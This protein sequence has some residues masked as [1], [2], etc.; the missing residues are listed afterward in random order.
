MRGYGA[1]RE[2]VIG[3]VLLHLFNHQAHHRG[4]ISLI[5]KI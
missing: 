5:W 1:Q 4:Q 2:S 3:H